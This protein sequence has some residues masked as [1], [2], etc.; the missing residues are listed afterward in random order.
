[1]QTNKSM[2]RFR[3]GCLGE[4]ECDQ[5]DVFWQWIIGDSPAPLPQGS[6]INARQNVGSKTCLVIV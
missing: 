6:K 1:M 3:A 2:E 5:L 4:R